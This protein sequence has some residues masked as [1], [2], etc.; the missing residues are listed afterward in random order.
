[1]R[2]PL[3]LV[4]FAF[5][6]ASASAEDIKPEKITEV[7]AGSVFIR[8]QIE[9]HKFSGSGFVISA[10]ADSLLIATNA[11]V[12]S[13][14]EYAKLP[15]TQLLG[16]LKQAKIT[17]LFGSGS[18]TEQS[19]PAEIVSLDPVVDVGILKVKLSAVKNP[20]KAL[21]LG[22][23]KALVETST[24]YSFGY[25]FGDALATGKGPAVTVGKASISSLRTDESGK[26]STIQ[27]DGNLNPGNSGGPV[28]DTDG[29]VI[30]VAT[31]ILRE[32]KGI[33][34]VVPVAEVESMLAGKVS[35]LGATYAKQPDGKLKVT[36]EAHVSNPAGTITGVT[37]NYA[38][39][40][41]PKMG[42]DVSTL[43]GA[44]SLT[45]QLEGAVAKGELLLATTAGQLSF[46]A[47]PTGVKKKWDSGMATHVSLT[48]AALGDKGLDDAKPPAGWKELS[49]DTGLY[50]IWVPEKSSK[51]VERTN[52]NLGQS[53]MINSTST[54]TIGDNGLT[55][56]LERAT[57]LLNRIGSK[58]DPVAVRESLSK[59]IAETMRGK[60]VEE[61]DA[62]MG[63]WPCKEYVIKG[64]K[65][66]AVVRIVVS[67]QT[68]YI[69]QVHGPAKSVTGDD[70]TLFL[71]SFRIHPRDAAA[72]DPNSPR[73]MMP[74]AAGNINAN[75][76]TELIAGAFDPVFRDYG[77]EGAFLV[78]FELGL[79]KFFDNDV[80]SAARPI[81]RSKTGETL[82]TAHGSSKDTKTLKAKEGYAVGTVTVRSGLTIDGLSLTFMKISG[83]K[84]DPKD[85]YE[86]EWVGSPKQFERK[87]GGTG[88]PFIGITGKANVQS[89]NLTGLGLI[90]DLPEAIE[91]RKNWSVGTDTDI[92][93]G[94]ND[95][96]YRDLTPEGGL[97]IGLEVGL[98]STDYI[99]AV[100][101]I[102]LTGG[103]ES[104][105]KQ[106]GK[107]IKRVV[108]LKA[109][110]GYAI[111]AVSA[112]SG[113]C[114][115]GMSVTFMKVV[116]GGLDPTDS[117]QSEYVGTK[118]Q[119]TP[120]TLSGGG[121]TVIGITG[122]LNGNNTGLGLILQAEK[123]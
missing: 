116:K 87:L 47:T 49:I 51:P 43:P 16:K 86:S 113:L 37:L 112:I 42:T 77:P 78:G 48:R 1:M 111:G 15:P 10:D 95:P 58:L 81:Y 93:G 44:K 53:Y 72:V 30:G 104:T 123:K 75:G 90:L 115:D 19:L 105:G 45:L 85:S 60:I 20:P 109:K 80:I 25:P 40:D 24:V 103:K 38:L 94:V 106:Y 76:E 41:K 21:K 110:A 9:T 99:I 100:R 66:T 64:T 117:Y 50:T 82:G 17:I 114:C 119:K 89:K 120:Q 32:G 14:E 65:Q 73:P 27:I 107:E 36:F 5:L 63:I 74:A 118:E 23:G 61:S 12:I 71:D 29:A 101:P 8:N 70:G 92:I 18:A 108:T 35:L 88:A 122:K 6:A 57:V 97:L 7:K 83:N 54:V 67:F 2:I 79:G 96:I 28:I 11:H 52:N 102:Y 4:S 22:G 59:S 13:P 39:G 69:L 62:K 33:G 121:K 98:N 91:A 55:Y 26:L 31:A 84:L 3:L 56:R 34:F 68:I 46:S